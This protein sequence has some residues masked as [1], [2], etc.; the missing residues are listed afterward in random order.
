MFRG[1]RQ[2]NGVGSMNE[3]EGYLKDEREKRIIKQ[4]FKEGLKEWLSEQ[5]ASFGWWT[6]K[7]V[8]AIAFSA[9]I[10]FFLATH[11]WKAPQI[12]P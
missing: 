9:L 11:G 2:R 6:V 10:Y 7:G 5:F 8:A 4:A 1:I 12:T 3:R